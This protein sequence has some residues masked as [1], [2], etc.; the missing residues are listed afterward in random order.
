M[1]GCSLSLLVHLCAAMFLW[2]RPPRATVAR[3]LGD[4]EEFL[5]VDLAPD[6][7]D[8]GGDTPPERPPDAAPPT[9]SPRPRPGRPPRRPAVIVTYEPQPVPPPPVSIAP[10]LADEGE[11]VEAETAIDQGPAA[12]PVTRRLLPNAARALRV[13]DVFPAMPDRPGLARVERARMVE[14]CVSDRGSVS[15]AVI[16]ERANDAFERTLRAAILTWRYRPLTVDGRPT[17]FC[18]LLHVSYRVD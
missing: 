8:P 13:Y 6:S 9:V 4:L 1:V 18:H 2:T 5:E 12:P 11:P 16:A 7:P 17:P 15:D 3:E 14:V 10:V